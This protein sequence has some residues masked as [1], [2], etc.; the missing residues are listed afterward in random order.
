M[1]RLPGVVVAGVEEK[2]EED[3][4]LNER[5]EWTGGAWSD[6]QVLAQTREKLENK[7]RK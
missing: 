4:L 2:E 3:Y 6:R 5:T 7:E 1:R